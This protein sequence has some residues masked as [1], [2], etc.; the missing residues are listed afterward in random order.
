[1]P[2]L[3]TAEQEALEN[4]LKY[5]KI[6]CLSTA[7]QSR[8]SYAWAWFATRGSDSAW[9]FGPAR[10]VGINDLSEADY[11][12]GNSFDGRRIER[13]LSAWFRE[14]PDSDPLFSELIGQLTE[15]LQRYGKAPSAKCRI[16]VHRGDLG[17]RPVS[18][19]DRDFAD[20]IIAA[21]L[22]L[23]SAE[24]DRIRSSI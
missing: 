11:L 10:F 13:Q 7:L 16:H 17:D 3:V 2:S 1:M 4:I 14:V 9:V 21:A 20:L 18:S 24:R 6:L 15:L 8:L 12:D 23:P 19:N 22:R 5:P